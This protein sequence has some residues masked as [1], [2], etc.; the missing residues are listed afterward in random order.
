MLQLNITIDRIKIFENKSLVAYI[1]TVPMSW[2]VKRGKKGWYRHGYPYGGFVVLKHY[3][4]Y[5]ILL[6]YEE[7]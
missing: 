7:A 3:W 4:I 5:V 1:L 2:R 6:I